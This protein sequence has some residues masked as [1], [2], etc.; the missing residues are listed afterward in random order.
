VKVGIEA[1]RQLF[2]ALPRPLVVSERETRQILEVN[3]AACELYGWT[4]DELIAMNLH[5]IRPPEDVEHFERVFQIASCD[6]VQRYSRAARHRTKDGRI[7]D[8]VLEISK[9]QLDDREVA[10][11]VVTDVSGVEDL[12]RRF[13]LM[14]E[15]SVDGIAMTGADNVIQYVSPGGVR[16]LGYDSLGELVGANALG[17]PHPDD[18]PHWAPPRPGEIRHHVARFRHRD[19]SWRWLESSTRNLTHDPAVRAYVANYRD[20]TDKV[21]S[22]SALR[23]SESNFRTL[24]ERAPVAMY[25]HQ[26]GRIVYANAAAAAMLGVPEA[27]ALIGRS[28]LDFIHPDDRDRVPEAGGRMVRADGTTFVLEGEAVRIDFDG[29]PCNLVMGHDVTAR[30]TMLARMAAAD[31][32]LSVG[33]LA[34]G[35]AHEINNPLAYVATNLEVLAEE[36][37]NIEVAMGSRLDDSALHNLVEDAREGVARVSA[38][39]RDLRALSRPEHDKRGPIDVTAAIAASLRMAHNEIRHRAR[40]VQSSDPNLPF[41]EADASRLGQVFLNLLLNAAHAIE[42]GAADRHEIRIDVTRQSDDRVRVDVRDTGSGIPASIL[43][44][45]F[46]PFFTT[47]APGAGIGLGLAIS[48]QI[49]NAMGGE[50]VVESQLGTGSKFSVFLP[51]ARTTASWP[52]EASH[53]APTPRRVLLI[54]DEAAVGR[55]LALLLA[56]ETE[57]VA[58]TRADEGLACLAAGERFDAIVCDLMMPQSTGMDLYDKL[59]RV[60]PEYMN[61]IVFMTG[62]AFTQQAREFLARVSRP[63]LAKPFSEEQLRRALASV[64]R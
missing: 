20:I 34:A 53:V 27:T 46:D 21:R 40:V 37:P 19:G 64:A 13:Q 28:L 41:V 8:V 45:I 35:V 51:V 43:P 29:L 5:D 25:V 2:D 32:M 50:I 31:R 24:I 15:Q 60:A 4:R 62:G 54:D 12:Q 6:S 63:H 49:V 59:E 30:D 22:E 36:L 61:K 1:Y 16:L 10:M 23:R 26:Q 55:S 57:V 44:R 3:R 17:M 14:V 39:V 38:I 56:P 58:V 9:V 42:P 48:H 47:K 52:P 7:L 33:T 18:I 11:S